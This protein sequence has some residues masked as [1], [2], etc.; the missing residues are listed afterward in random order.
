MRPEQLRARLK[1]SGTK[2]VHT[3]W[4]HCDDARQN[5]YLDLLKRTWASFRFEERPPTEPGNYPVRVRTKFTVTDHYFR[6]IAKMGFHYYLT[7]TKRGYR[8]D[9]K[10]FK[11]I[12]H[13]IMEGGN[14]DMFFKAPGSRFL[15]PCDVSVGGFAAFPSNWCHVLAG[16]E[17][18]DR[19]VAYVRLF[20]GPGFRPLPHHVNLGL[21]EGR[22]V[23]PSG[24]SAH[25]YLYDKVQPRSGFA[26]RV[27][28]L[29]LTRRR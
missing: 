27:E 3:A 9:E 26:G 25:I 13:F 1:A 8:G 28:P 15:L 5:D 7:H 4:L 24:L 10:C 6:A 21:L 20:L 14:I 23:V 11:A 12:R 29:T 16:D 18:A 17:S 2:T 19:V 22:V